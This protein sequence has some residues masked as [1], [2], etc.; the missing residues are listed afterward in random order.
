MRQILITWLS[1][2]SLTAI[3]QK[4]QET[5]TNVDELVPQGWSHQEASGDLNKDGIPDLAV[6]ALPDFKEHLYTRDDG[7]VYNFNQPLFAIYFGTGDNELRLWRQ[8]DEIIPRDE[9]EYASNEWDVSITERG[10]L[11]IAVSVFYSAGS[12]TSPSATYVYRYQDGDFYLI[13]KDS[14]SFARNTGVDVVVSENYITHKQQTITSNGFDEDEKTVEKWKTLPKNP[15]KLLG[16][17]LEP[18]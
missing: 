11:R 15:L 9:D 5:G 10:A 3:A 18:F 6:I 17:K 12:W 7:Y 14:H 4:L 13:G 8:Y 2:L 1:L 16:D